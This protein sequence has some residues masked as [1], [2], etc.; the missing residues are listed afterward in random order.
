MQCSAR[1]KQSGERCKKDAVAGTTVCHIHGG[2]S[3]KGAD[4]P[5]FKTGQY[6]RYRQHLSDKIRAKLPTAD[7]NPFDLLPELEVQ[8]TLFADYLSR[9]HSGNFTADDIQRLIDWSSD[10][11]KMVERIA[12]QRNEDAL[13][14]A[15]LAFLAARIAD[16]V[17]RHIHDPER[18]RAFIA[19]LF[20]EIPTSHRNSLEARA[21][22]DKHNR[23]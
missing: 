6:S 13:T 22:G 7:D 1:S 9:F 16:V 12:K 4:S 8:R 23:R 19:D 17:T 21:D 18:Q 20:A 15:E 10:I 3:L 5:A 2:K 14:G 11:G